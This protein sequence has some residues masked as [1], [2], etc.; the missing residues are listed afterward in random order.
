MKI[1]T[2]ALVLLI[3]ALAWSIPSSAYAWVYST[4]HLYYS[5]SGFV[6]L[7]GVESVPGVACIPEYERDYWGDIDT[8]Y[9][10]IYFFNECGW[11]DPD[12]A[13]CQWYYSGSWHIVPCS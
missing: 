12:S 1:R 13:E 7:V 11:D 6:N 10:I 9:R 2:L 3:G 4:Q 8:D 5:D